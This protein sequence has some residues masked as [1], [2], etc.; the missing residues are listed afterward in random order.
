MILDLLA[1]SMRAI[2]GSVPDIDP[3]V[4]I[5]VS[6]QFSSKVLAMESGFV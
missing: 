6:I 1:A 5:T 2:S 4:E 3:S